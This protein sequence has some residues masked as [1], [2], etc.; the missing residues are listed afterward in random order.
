MSQ[1]TTKR[2]I[3]RAP[4]P[5]DAEALFAIDSDPE[6]NRY[7]PGGP[8]RSAE[9]S[10]ARL[11]D[12]LTHWQTNQFGYW[13]V[14]T[15]AQPDWIIGFGGIAYRAI[16]GT[17]RLNLFFRFRP[18]AWGYGYATEMGRSAIALGFHTLDQEHIVATV[19]PANLPSIRALERL[20]LRYAGD[21]VDDY[22]ISRRYIIERQ[23]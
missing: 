2:L 6:T 22:G 13:A 18:E 3:L 7:N 21:I 16:E 11:Q 15:C 14:A 1:I 23:P 9:Q 10:L 5:G 8:A 19:R 12:W 4:W 17:Q 20:G